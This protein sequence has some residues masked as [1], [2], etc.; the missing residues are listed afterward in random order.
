MNKFRIIFIVLLT[1]SAIVGCKKDEVRVMSVSL[2]K[3]SLELVEG[4]SEKLT[5]AIAPK[6][7]DNQVVSWSSSDNAIASVDDKGMVLAVKEGKA[8]IKVTTAD[9]GKTASCTVTVKSKSVSVTGVTLDKSE[10]EITEGESMTLV[11][12]VT[13][14][15]ASVKSVSWKS[16]DETVTTVDE[17]GKVTALK[18]GTS[19]ITVTTVD[20]GKTAACAVTVN[21]K[22]YPVES[23][24][25]DATE[26]TLEQGETRTLVPTVLP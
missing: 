7:A 23:V 26:L 13:P 18:E 25:L 22:I 4:Q 11:A 5:P 21:A 2:D 1:I 3:T 19:T 24:S 8:T 20:G 16:S 9:G 14:E 15:D 10:L 6:D 12:T 17:A